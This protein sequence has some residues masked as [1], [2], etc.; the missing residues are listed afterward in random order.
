MGSNADPYYGRPV[1][2]F[3]LAD[4]SASTFVETEAAFLKI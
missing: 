1:V 3:V 4:G 2:I